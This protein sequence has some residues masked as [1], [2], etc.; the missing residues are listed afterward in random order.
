MAA[1]PPAKLKTTWLYKYVRF[2]DGVVLFCD[3]CDYGETHK[4]L[5]DSRPE[6]PAVSAGNVQFRHKGWRIREG[7]S[8]TAKLSRLQSDEKYIAREIEP[9]GFKYDDE[10]KYSL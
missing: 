3:A 9:H 5:V 2:A 4:G 10:L 6:V 7:G 8:S 1:I